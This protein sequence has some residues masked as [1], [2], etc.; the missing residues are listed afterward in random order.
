MTSP[1]K[2]SIQTVYKAVRFRSKLEADWARVF[3][4]LGIHW[5]YEPQGQYF[6]DTFY[7]VD[8]WL[9]ASRQWVE[10][11]GKAGPS[12]LIKMAALLRHVTP[13]RFTDPEEC[14]DIALV[15]CE[16]GGRF[17]GWQRGTYD[18]LGS[19]TSRLSMWSRACVNVT[20][21]ACLECGGW[22]FADPNLSWRCQCCGTSNGNG[23]VA[24]EVTSPL[25][26]FPDL[27]DI[28]PLGHGAA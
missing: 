15:M 6:G 3:D 13:R 27:I 9:P 12:D 17:T 24:S 21:F 16:P 20:A 14:P 4:A 26:G 7:L 23:H 28:R 10:V 19:L 22:W 2:L 1:S 8:F 25:T 18:P 5:D 11:K